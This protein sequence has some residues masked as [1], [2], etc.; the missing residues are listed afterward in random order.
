[1]A[2][3]EQRNG[4]WTT[5]VSLT[6]PA[7]G[8][9]RQKRVTAATK[10]ELRVLVADAE[11]T[12]ARGDTIDPTKVTVAEFIKL[13]VE[14]ADIA[15]STRYRELGSLEQYIQPDPIGSMRLQTVRPAHVQAWVDR[16]SRKLAPSSVRSHFGLM[17]AAFNR[18]DAL[19]VV[20]RT[21]CRGIRL[22]KP[23]ASTHAILSDTQARA[24][25]SDKG[26]DTGRHLAWILAVVVGLRQGEILGLR[27]TDLNE[28]TGALTINRTMTREKS[29]VWVIGDGAKTF[30]SSR[31]FILPTVALRAMKSHR[32]A[33]VIRR[34]AAGPAW[35]TDDAIIDNGN[36][37]HHPTPYA[38]QSAWRRTAHRLGFPS[39]ITMHDLRHTCAS[40]AIRAHVPITSISR[41]L[42]HADPSITLKVYA[43]VFA[44][45]EEETASL[46]DG[47]Y[48]VV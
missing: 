46:I 41:M 42:G 37:A 6:D 26:D 48:A 40:L 29:K 44:E 28:A 27:W 15:E 16:I 13:H 12:H 47:I 31:T 38:L 4:M 33:Q 7:T 23:G 34:L 21:P 20:A 11:S 22:P 30:A 1:M 14:R 43:H 19:E 32:T 25:E 2:K 18:A 5:R 24:L 35:S 3:V 9:R 8:Q 39:D 10:R 36:G 17:R 45:M